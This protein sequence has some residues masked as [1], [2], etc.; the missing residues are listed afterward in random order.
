MKYG[1]LVKTTEQEIDLDREAEA[2]EKDKKVLAELKKLTTKEMAE[3]WEQDNIVKAEFQINQR[4][5]AFKDLLKE[6]DGDNL[7]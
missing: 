3:I 6:K 4:E 7:E 5:K 2:I 1:K